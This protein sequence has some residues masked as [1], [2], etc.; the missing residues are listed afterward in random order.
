MTICTASVSSYRWHKD[1]LQIS[2]SPSVG[3]PWEPGVRQKW[4]LSAS[5]CIKFLKTFW[6]SWSFLRRVTCS[7]VSWWWIRSQRLAR[8]WWRSWTTESESSNS[9][10]RTAAPRRSTSFTSAKIERDAVSW[11]RHAVTSGPLLEVQNEQIRQKKFKI[12]TQECIKTRRIFSLYPCLSWSWME[13][14]LTFVV[15]RIKALPPLQ[16]AHTRDNQW[17][18]TRGGVTKERWRWL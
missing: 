4:R 6:E 18:Y 9:S 15:C 17:R 14:A 2:M 13:L 12:I 16:N 3:K 5:T 1:V 10:T 8:P 11:N 7:A